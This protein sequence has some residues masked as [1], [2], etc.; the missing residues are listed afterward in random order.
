MVKHDL[1]LLTLLINECYATRN[2]VHLNNRFNKFERH[3]QQVTAFVKKN[4]VAS[5]IELT[6]LKSAHRLQTDR[7]NVLENKVDKLES[8][9][10]RIARLETQRADADRVRSVRNVQYCWVVVFFA[11]IDIVNVL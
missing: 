6:K 10:A 2:W 8:L 1:V 4:V 5:N 3:S 9:E 7:I 11:E